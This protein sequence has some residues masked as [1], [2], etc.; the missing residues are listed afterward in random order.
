MYINSSASAI[1]TAVSFLEMKRRKH[2][3]CLRIED[4]G[5]WLFFC[6]FVCFFPFELQ[7]VSLRL[8]KSWKILDLVV[9]KR[10]LLM[11]KCLN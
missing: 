7:P 1:R 8:W 10:E 5:S 3:V 4:Y 6:L 9:R 11:V 2:Q